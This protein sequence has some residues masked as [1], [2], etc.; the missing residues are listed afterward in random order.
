MRDLIEIDG[1]NSR[2][3]NIIRALRAEQTMYRHDA[4]EENFGRLCRATLNYHNFFGDSG[5]SRNVQAALNG[6]E[7][8]VDPLDKSK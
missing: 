5:G 1:E 4:S 2:I 6:K 7:T 8:L 3:G